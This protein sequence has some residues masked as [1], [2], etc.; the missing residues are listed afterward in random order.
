MKL[1]SHSTT[2]A[3]GGLLCA[4]LAGMAPASAQAQ[5][6]A[7]AW[8]WQAAIYGWFPALSGTT[9]FPSG[10]GGPSFDVS[11]HQVLESLNFAFMGAFGGKKGQWGFWTDLFYA[12]VGGSKDGTRDFSLGHQGLPANLS[13]NLNLDIKTT[14]WTLAGTYELAKSPEYVADVLAGARGINMRQTLDWS[15][16]GDIAGTGLPSQSGSKELT[17]TNWDAIVGVKGQAFLDADRKWFVPYY[18]DI[19]GGQSKLTWQINAGIGYR[20]GWGA[21]VA[22]WRVL[23]YDMKSGD[24]IQSIRFNGPLV[25]AAFQ[26]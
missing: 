6:S 20:F 23:D 16:N 4:V 9:E 15:I 7:D 3:A 18:A 12:D 11:T 13:A 5:A 2:S 14:I 1:H 26:W 10:A 19:G 22:S 24:P 21:L 17:I 25:G 8:Q